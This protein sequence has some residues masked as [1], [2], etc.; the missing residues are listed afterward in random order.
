MGGVV[1][2]LVMVLGVVILIGVGFWVMLS[3]EKAATEKPKRYVC[4][5]CGEK[6]CDC[7]EQPKR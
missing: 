6:H 3:K 4:S 2:T 5:H 7:Y 1:L